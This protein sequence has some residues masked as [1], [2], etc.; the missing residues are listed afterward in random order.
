MGSYWHMIVAWTRVFVVL[1]VKGG[2]YV[3]SR[4]I[5]K[6]TAFGG[7]LSV[8]SKEEFTS[9]DSWLVRQLM[10]LLVTEQKE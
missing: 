8:G 4:G 3:L 1:V 7:M 9:K 5:Y 10:M 2:E 6:L